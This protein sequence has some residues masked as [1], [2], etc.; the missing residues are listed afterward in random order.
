MPPPK[1]TTTELLAA[2]AAGDRDSLRTIY[3]TQSARL[4]GIAYAILR[5]RPAAADALQEAFVRIW[6]RTRQ[7]DPA[8]ADADAWLAAAVRHAALDIARARGREAGDEARNAGA[9]DPDSLDA[10]AATEPGTRLRGALLKLEP[11]PRA[12]VVLGFVH[13][14]S[15]AE[16]TNRLN[17]PAGAA[18]SWVRRGLAGL[19]DGLV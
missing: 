2:V 18:R 7:F 12:A 5:D 14:F 3:R 8:R 13:G 15:Y 9:V 1:G 17:E 16:L 19:R 6:Q 10:L 4:F 11:K